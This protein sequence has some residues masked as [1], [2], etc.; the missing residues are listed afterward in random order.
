MNKYVV[1]PGTS[2]LFH[3]NGIAEVANSGHF[4][5][6][7][8]ISFDQRQQIEKTRKLIA[9]YQ[10]SSLGNSRS[11]MRARPVVRRTMVRNRMPQRPSTQHSRIVS[12]APRH[13]KE[14]TPRSYNP[15]S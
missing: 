7:S 10:K 15:Y 8:D 1:K 4:G 13:F 6:S 11:I 9:S 12:V 14:P 2:K 5:T 3:N